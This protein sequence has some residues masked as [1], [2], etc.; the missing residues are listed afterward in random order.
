MVEA[1]NRAKPD[2]LWVGMTAPK[3]EKWTYLNRSELNVPLIGPVGAVFDYFAGTARRA[4]PSFQEMGLE[5][6]PRL[7][8]DPR[9]LWRRN[10]ISNPAFLARVAAALTTQETV[11]DGRADSE[12]LEE[13]IYGR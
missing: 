10:L 6:L 9:H 7:L 11:S 2:V 3:Q 13:N 4:H 5:W 1:V 12:G 8:S